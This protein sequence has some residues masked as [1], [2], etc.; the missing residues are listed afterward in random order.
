MTGSR[1]GRCAP[2]RG[3]GQG[4]RRRPRP[5][6]W[7]LACLLAL[8]AVQAPAQEALAQEAPAQPPAATHWLTPFAEETVTTD[9]NVFRIPNDFDPESLIGSQSRGDTYRTTSVG[10]SADVPVSLQ[11]FTATLA[12]NGTRYD[13][14]HDLDFDGYAAR[15][16]WL[17]Q[18]GRTAS[19][20]VGVTDSYSLAPFEELLSVV[21]DK[22]KVREEFANGS[23][24]VTPEWKLHGVLDQLV[25]SNSDPAGLFNDVTVNSAEG[26]LSR[27][28][29][30]GNSLGLDA[31]FEHGEFP[32]L[33]PVGSELIDNAY[34]QYSA[35]V[36]LDWG[37]GLP[38][39]VVARA[40]QVH[41]HYDELSQRD[42]DGTTAHVDYTWNP[43]A[44]VDVTATAERDISPYEYVHSSIVLLKG[45]ALRPL[46]RATEKIDVSADIEWMERTYLSDPVVALGLAPQRD[47]HVRT[48]SALLAYRP[49]EHVTLQ[50]SFVHEER[51]SNI[52]L[53]GYADDTLWVRGRVSL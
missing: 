5:A 46:W 39:H 32:N 31:R 24:L 19:G 51:S 4:W 40:D 37:A 23:W 11:R 13:R 48:E 10:V 27:V 18:Y 41:R 33:E 7:G 2:G 17:W 42:F 1:K 29:A 12:Y 45:L 20:E 53:G 22:I 50:L 35:G 21:P 6:G 43:T 16:S 34:D 28:S 36:V 47:D 8:A 30:L 49:L 38:S 14:F 44:K 15:G 26:S 52:P 9:D 3:A 25:Q